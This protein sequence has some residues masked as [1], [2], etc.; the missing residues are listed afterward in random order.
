MA[1]D[2]VQQVDSNYSVDEQGLSTNLE[3]QVEVPQTLLT[4]PQSALEQLN[5]E[6][7]PLSFSEN[8]GIELYEETLRFIAH[9]M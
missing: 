7:D 8:Y 9:S 4:I 2:F 3:P 5:L 6:V 1:L